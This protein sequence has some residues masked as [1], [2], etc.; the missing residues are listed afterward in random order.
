MY[1]TTLLKKTRMINQ[2]AFIGIMKEEVMTFLNH[3]HH[4]N[5][6]DNVMI[7]SNRNIHTHTHKKS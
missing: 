5:K 2:N 6:N 3:P 7:K 4:K 1:F